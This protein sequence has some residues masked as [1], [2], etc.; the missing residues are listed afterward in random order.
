MFR[1]TTFTAVFLLAAAASTARA[2]EAVLAEVYGEGVH[3]YF[4][5]EYDE[6][7]KDF[8]LAIE[9][10]LQDPRVYYF[11]GL[12]AAAT[13]R[14]EEAVSDWR[15]GAV[16]E[17][18]GN[19]TGSIGRALARIQGAQRLELEQVRQLVR[20]EERARA[21]ARS[22][23]RYEAPEDAPPRS[24]RNVDP[25]P[26]EPTPAVPAPPTPAAPED[27]T[28]AVP[29]A[30]EDVRTNPFADDGGIV[31]GDA[32]LESEDAL[33]DPFIEPTPAEDAPADADDTPPAADEFFGGD[34]DEETDDDNPFGDF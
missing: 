14:P 26:A 27:P 29:P 2:Q 25:A 17:A 34:A 12:T 4:A 19:Y 21:A 10:G 18:R 33:G 6:A 30:P 11:R 5:H 9:H 13:G 20:V 23:A 7:Y 3:H 16:Q 15:T 28:P 8:T 1:A 24:P 31:E 22:R 32:I